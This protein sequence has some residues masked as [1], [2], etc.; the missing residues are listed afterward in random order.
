MA[1]N[2]YI[3]SL[4]PCAGAESPPPL[5]GIG[6]A[7]D[8]FRMRHFLLSLILGTLCCGASARSARYVDYRYAPQDQVSTIC[9]PDDTCKTIVGPQGQLLYGFGGKRFFTYIEGKRGFST[10]IQLLADENLKFAEQKLHSARVPIVETAATCGGLEI[11]QEAFAY[12]EEFMERGVP[13]RSGNREDILLTQIKN[14]TRAGRIVRPVVVVNSERPVR[15]EG[16]SVIVDSTCRFVLSHPVGRVRRNLAD[17]KTLIELEPIEVPAG[18]SRLVAG[19]CDNAKRS[20]LADAFELNATPLLND[21][22]R[23]RDRA[24]RYWE[25]E[26]QIPYGRVVVPDAEIQ[27][28]LDASVRGIWQAREVAGRRYNFQVGPT[29]YRVLYIVDGAFILETATML[30]RGDQARSGIEYMLSF[31]RENGQFSKLTRTYWKESGIVLWAC[32]RHAMLTQDKAWLRSVWPQLSKAVGF[33]RSLRERSL[34]NDNP[35]DDGLI[36]P[37]YIDGGLEGGPEQAEYTNVLWN[38]VGLQA[39]VRAAGWLGEAG[40]AARWQAEY[41]DFYAAFRRAAERDK[42]SDSFG[43]IYLPTVMD[44]SYHTLP[45]R[46]QWAFC[47]SIY[48]GQI[49][50]PDD[51][52]A[53]GTLDMLH[54][55]LQQGMVMGTGWII[56]GI[57]SYFASFYGHAS[58]WMG[59]PGRAADALY[60]FANHASPLWLWR[61][62]HNPRDLQG[63]KYIG[64]MPHNWGSAEFIRLATHLLQIDRGS[65][66]HLLEGIPAEWLGPGMKTALNGVAT[67]FG[68]LSFRLEVDRKGNKA[69]LA[70]DRLPDSSCTALVVHLGEWGGPGGGR[71]LRLNPH[72]ANTI[73]IDL[74]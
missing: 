71:T 35:L 68:P 9:F 42:L 14:P 27:H 65:E 53:R 56:E 39:M 49:F 13:T 18:E 45:Q 57:W 23:L 48:P 54:T 12:A 29:C 50:G 74:N 33:I 66:L 73:E 3:Y 60:A 46:A 4:L 67:P 31:Q 8:P 40:D 11:L 10:V 26:A 55:T 5:G 41:D 30:G 38:L 2:N 28:L 7:T 61:E 37:G 36:E 44:P 52:L 22:P 20:T 15:V 6:P 72:E 16:R 1:E 70:V 62:E 24:V 59:S 47:Q 58:L 63:D 32:V 34:L 21:L 17:F 19:V 25:E 51:P 69:R 43:N 64:D